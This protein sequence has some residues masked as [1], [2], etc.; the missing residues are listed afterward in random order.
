M[1]YSSR[2]IE[3]VAQ[4]PGNFFELPQGIEDGPDT[5]TNNA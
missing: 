5:L 1:G 2:C 3:A 4:A